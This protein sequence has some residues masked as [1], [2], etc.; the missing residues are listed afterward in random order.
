[1]AL[2][3]NLTCHVSYSVP[4]VPGALLLIALALALVACQVPDS[5]DENQRM[6]VAV[7]L[8]PLTSDRASTGVISFTDFDGDGDTDLFVTNGYDVSSPNPAPQANRL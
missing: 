6:F 5:A 4:S 1:M 2:N 3:H 8:P 7:E